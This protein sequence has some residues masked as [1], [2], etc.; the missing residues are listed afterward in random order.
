[1]SDFIIINGVEEFLKE[2]A[3]SNIV[4]SGLFDEVMKYSFPDEYDDYIDQLQILS[5]EK[6]ICY[7]VYNVKDI[8]DLPDHKNATVI[9]VTSVGYKLNSEKASKV[10]D[11][12]K[13][14]THGKNNEII[15]FIIDEGKF[16]QIDLTRV[17]HALFVSCGDCLRKLSS[18]IEKIALITSPGS[19][20]TLEEIRGIISFSVELSPQMV[21]DCIIA[22]KSSA[23]MSF[24]DKLQE[25]A[26][27]TGLIIA[28]MQRH[29]LQ[30]LQVKEMKDDGIND[31]EAAELL[32]VNPYRYLNQIKP[33][34][35]VWSRSLLL[36]SLDKLC[37]IDISH[38]R[39]KHFAKFDLQLEIIRLSEEAKRDTI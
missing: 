34:S 27:E 19:V 9:L 22:G 1:V 24:H 28:Y 33:L 12:P 2:R 36:D 7:I 6:K 23:A 5:F 13:L 14:K 15:K 10:L 8:P 35:D 25:S 17:A 31:L 20:V 11:F 30:Q 21:I 3:V 18:E 39:G 29:V 37:E 26:D 16:Y 32:K 4:E 38:K